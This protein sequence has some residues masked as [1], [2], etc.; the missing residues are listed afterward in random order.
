MS[1][2]PVSE[3]PPLSGAGCSVA[4]EPMCSKVQIGSDLTIELGTLNLI[5]LKM[6]LDTDLQRETTH[7]QRSKI[8]LCVYVS[9]C[10]GLCLLMCVRCQSWSHFSPNITS[11]LSQSW[12]PV[13][14]SLR[15]IEMARESG[16]EL[17]RCW[18]FV[19]HLRNVW[20]CVH[21]VCNGRILGS[22]PIGPPIWKMYACMN[23]SH[24]K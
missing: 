12:V 6:E 24:F 10:A 5:L 17:D 20:S 14:T 21:N 1:N 3:L 4:V 8:H 2:L 7:T 19:N 16:T 11:R 13:S 9:T 18:R 23:V 22:I 15:N